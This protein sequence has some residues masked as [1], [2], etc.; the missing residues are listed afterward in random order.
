MLLVSPH[1]SCV[2]SYPVSPHTSVSCVSAELHP[3]FNGGECIQKKSCDCGRYNASGSRCQIVYNTGADREN[4]CRT[5]GQY[6]YETFDGVYYYYPGTSTYDLL[7]QSDPEEPSF[8]I[9]VHNDR[10]CGPRPYSCRRSLSLYFAGIGEITLQNRIVLHNNVRVGLPYT[11][12]NVKIQA[13]S[14][15][16]VVRQQ[17]VFSM[18]W[19]GNSS[20]YLKMSPDYFGRTHGLCGNNNWIPQDDLVTS[21]GKLTENIEEFVNSWREDLPHKSS[22][23]AP[24]LYEPPCAKTSP[25]V[26]Q[27]SHSLC[28]ALLQDPF[29]TCHHVVSPSPFMASCATDLCRIMVTYVGNGDLLRVMVTSVDNGDLSG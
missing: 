15:Y 28:S 12:G 17:Y 11:V 18:A 21:Y 25:R 2:P 24:F 27:M 9:Q 14:G 29:H 19:D 13:V 16:V 10:D 7:R 22:P 20:V 23:A 5:W 4:I 26:T 3:C 8:A 1:V 6:H